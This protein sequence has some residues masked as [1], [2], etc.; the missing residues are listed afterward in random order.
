[1]ATPA[2][3][4]FHFLL[5]LLGW[6]TNNSVRNVWSFLLNIATKERNSFSWQL[7]SQSLLITTQMSSLTVRFL[8]VIS[9]KTHAS[10]VMM[11]VYVCD[12]R[13]NLWSAVPL[14]HWKLL[15]W[16]EWA[17]N[18]MRPHKKLWWGS[19]LLKW[20]SL[21]TFHNCIILN[22]ALHFPFAV[23]QPQTAQIHLRLHDS[24]KELTWKTKTFWSK[25]ISCCVEVKRMWLLHWLVSPCFLPFLR[26]MLN[27][28]EWLICSK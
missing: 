21:K 2:L 4:F 13:N 23:K 11:F 16:V 3:C 28:K 24:I 1:M 12:E 6:V 7:A 15:K 8:F 20:C 10:F 17:F 25:W 14:H 9:W 26:A 27:S 19:F 18:L 5:S 22:I